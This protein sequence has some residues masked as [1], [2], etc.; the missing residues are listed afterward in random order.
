MVPYKP[1]QGGALSPEALLDVACV[2]SYKDTACTNLKTWFVTL[3]FLKT[4]FMVLC[5][6][7][8][9][10]IVQQV[11]GSCLVCSLSEFDL[12]HPMWSPGQCQE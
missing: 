7:D 11:L 8:Q 12:W 4:A 9:R 3:H 1:L 2:L 10:E 6:R 5:A